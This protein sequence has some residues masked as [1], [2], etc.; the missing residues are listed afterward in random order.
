MFISLL[1]LKRGKNQKL[2]NFYTLLIKCLATKYKKSNF[3][4]GTTKD[5]LTDSSL[6]T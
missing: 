1:L 3:E 4:H 5:Y 6:E 2:C